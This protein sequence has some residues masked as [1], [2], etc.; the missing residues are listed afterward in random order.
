LRLRPAVSRPA[1]RLLVQ[2]V[3]KLPSTTTSHSRERPNTPLRTQH[4]TRFEQVLARP[5]HV[6][7]KEVI[8]SVARGR[9]EVALRY[10]LVPAYPVVRLPRGSG[11]ERLKRIHD[12]L[13][14]EF[15]GC[16]HSHAV[17]RLL[18]RRRPVGP[19]DR[20]ALIRSS[21]TLAGSSFGS[22][23]TSSPRNAL[24]RIS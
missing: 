16:L 8:L 24:A 23:G 14:I 4:D 5:P 3:I 22:C 11:A 15:S 17:A 12:P 13:S 7:F 10:S 21:S 18:F 1:Q 2:S 20:S 6:L 19:A 9:G